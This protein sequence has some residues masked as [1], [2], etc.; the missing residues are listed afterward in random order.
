MWNIFM[1]LPKKWPE[2][3]VKWATH[4]VVAFICTQS[5]FWWKFRRKIQSKNHKAI[6]VSPVSNRVKIASQVQDKVIQSTKLIWKSKSSTEIALPCPFEII[7]L[8]YLWSIE[9]FYF[10]PIFYSIQS[11]RKKYL[12]MAYNWLKMIESKLSKIS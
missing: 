4:T 7:T 11:I 5:I 8:W 9:L 10:R 6:K 1:W 2:M 3:V 12:K